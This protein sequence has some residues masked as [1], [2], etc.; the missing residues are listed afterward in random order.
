M[1]NFLT[2]DHKLWFTIYSSINPRPNHSHPTF[3]I[4]TL[5]SSPFKNLPNKKKKKDQTGVTDKVNPQTFYSILNLTS[6][7]AGKLAVKHTTWH[8]LIGSHV[9]DVPYTP[10]SCCF[11]PRNQNPR[12]RNKAPPT[13]VIVEIRYML[14]LERETIQKRANKKGL[15]LNCNLSVKIATL[16][17]R[18]VDSWFL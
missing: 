10:H 14:C 2:L 1:L 17:I 5:K 15:F 4:L 13:V 11:F 12:E 7:T 18:S 3:N 9:Y 8:H 16:F 6:V